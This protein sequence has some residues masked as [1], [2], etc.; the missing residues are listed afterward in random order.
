M[1]DVPVCAIDETGIHVP[2]F[3]DCLSYFQDGYRSI[4][5]QDTYLGNDS[6]DGQWAA[7]Q[8]LAMHDANS[9]ALAAYNAFSP[10]TAQ[11]AG[12]S[13][14]VKINGIARGVATYSTASLKL[15]GQAGAIIAN[16]VAADADGNKWAL[17][18]SVTIP[19]SGEITVTATAADIGAISAPAGTITTISTPTLGWQSVTNPAA[20]SP[21]APVESDA[22]LRLRQSK[23]AS[24][25]SVAIL[26][27]IVA[28]LLALT[29]VT[30]VKAFENDANI[31]DADGIPGHAMAIV[32][33][34]GDD[35]EIAAVIALKKSPGTGTYGTSSQVVTNAYG[36]PRAI[37]FFR[38]KMVPITVRITLRALNGFTAATQANIQQ[39]ISD[40]I[41][42]FTIGDDVLLDELYVPA[43]LNVATTAPT[44]RISSILMARGGQPMTASDAVMAFNEAAFSKPSYVGIV[45]TSS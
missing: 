19:V 34:G 26:D 31:P 7:L 30:R 8:A 24:L 25:P 42:T 37:S 38:P 41:N 23:S 6:Q 12:L 10:A 29:G 3:A 43:R 40:F 1:S 13:S 35:A 20:S 17:P 27:G 21:G 32:V 45:V 15:I 9:M 44:Y 28:A 16:G 36:I 33:E 11:G 18:A 5:G 2:A 22:F 39:A 14:V 4:F